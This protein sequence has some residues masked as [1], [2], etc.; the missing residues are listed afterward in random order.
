[1]AHQM[2]SSCSL[3]LAVV[4]AIV[5]ATCWVPSPFEAFTGG[6]LPP[7]RR[8]S[9][10][11]ARAAEGHEYPEL[12]RVEQMI[13]DSCML[14]EGMQEVQC[15]R[16]LSKLTKFHEEAALECKMDELNCLVLDVLDRLCAG[17]QGSDGLIV[18]NRV[19]SAVLSFREK[20]SDWSSAFKAADTD[21][22]GDLDLDELIAAMKSVD[23]GMTEEQVKMI[24]FA[25]DANG[26]GVISAEEFSNFLTAAVFAEEPLRGLQVDS[27]PK[28]QPAFEEYLRWSMSGRSGSWAAMR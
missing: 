16:T 28:K 26:D 19:T 5:L 27:L 24:F 7:L 1:M 17:I 18:L 2:K 6:S 25:A 8:A 23:S 3:R 4:A 11:V 15:L 21:G 14:R 20:F 10:S 13:Y 9:S 12:Q 22:S